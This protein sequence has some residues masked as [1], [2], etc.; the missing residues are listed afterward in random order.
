ME[1][2]GFHLSEIKTLLQSKLGD[3]HFV[4]KA[5]G[6]DISFY[7]PNNMKT[8]LPKV[9]KVS[10]KQV[11]KETKNRKQPNFQKHN[12][13]KKEENKETHLK[14][15]RITNIP[16]KYQIWYLDT[17]DS[18]AIEQKKEL[19]GLGVRDKAVDGI[20]IVF[21]KEN[22]CLAVYFIELKSSLP[23]KELEKIVEKVKHS[24][25]RFLLFLCLNEN[26]HSKE[27]FVNTKVEFKTILFFN[28]MADKI[29]VSED[30][31][32]RAIT[33]TYQKMKENNLQD[34][35][36]IPVFETLLGNTPNPFKFVFRDAEEIITISFD[37][38]VKF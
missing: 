13:P 25:S 27:P 7:E 32:L 11:A 19:I 17:W 26:K 15:V 8:A 35:L 18:Q 23:N 24:I 9:E 12:E 37:D 1:K 4:Q 10:T 33:K 29:D 21:D 14:E 2:N 3:L 38:L 5:E 30:T 31:E 22:Q 6:K 16:K 28:R 36:C 34:K 20:L